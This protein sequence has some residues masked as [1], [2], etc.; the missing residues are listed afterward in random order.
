MIDY[1]PLIGACVGDMASLATDNYGQS[2]NQES[3]HEGG[4]S[5]SHRPS[6]QI[7][8]LPAPLLNLIN[9]GLGNSSYFVFR[10]PI[11]SLLLLRTDILSNHFARWLGRVERQH[12]CRGEKQ[13][14]RKLSEIRPTLV[15]RERVHSSGGSWR[16]MCSASSPFGILERARDIR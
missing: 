13:P 5:Q 12:G 2:V 4:V 10:L 15:P 14:T 7:P 3:K 6:S 11:P 1:C 16:E 9:P 8:Y